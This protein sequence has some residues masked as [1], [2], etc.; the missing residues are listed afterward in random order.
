MR[1]D[2]Q[3]IEAAKELLL[4]RKVKGSLA[5]WCRQCGFEPA[6]HHQLLINE[7]E[8][9][10]RGECQFL[11]INMPPGSAK[12]TYTSKSLPGWYLSRLPHRTI[13]SCS[14]SYTLAEGFGRA[15]RNLVKLNSNLL[16]IDLKADSK[17]AGEWETTNE[18]R[19]FCAGTNAGIAG[20]RADLGLIDDPIGSQED[21]DSKLYRDKQWD[22]Y[23]NDFLPRLKPGAAVIII[24][25]RRHEDD[26]IGRL[27]ET[28][29]AKWKVISFPMEAEDHDILGRKPGERLWPE[30]FTDAMVAT[31]KKNPRTWNG[32]YQQHPTAEQGDFFQKEWLL[33]Y[34]M[35]ELTK[36]EREGLRFYATSDHAIGRNEANNPSCFMPF[37]VDLDDTVWVLP[38]VVWKQMDSETQVNEMF[39]IIRRR[40]PMTWFAEKGHIS[41]SIGPF[42]HKRMREERVYCNIEEM[43]PTRDKRARAQ[44]IHGRMSMRKVRF[45]HFAGWWAKAEHELLS[46]TG[47]GGDKSDD[48]VDALAWIGL[49]LDKYTKPQATPVKQSQELNIEFKPTVAWLKDLDRQQQRRALARQLDY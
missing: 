21:A 43:V 23:W 11:I 7:L 4:R 33:P 6:A 35:D 42:L 17:S 34:T 8:A 20:H 44:S 15:A 27:L 19:Y 48:F 18:G 3:T 14:Y 46:F 22:W 39:D 28:E 2:Q 24:A 47:S 9:V 16:E 41:S 38:D 26:L 13:L 32:L 36:V 1:V 5:A 31:A 12:S 40:R 49:G 10:E 45:P 30:Y 37:A 29:P 25:N